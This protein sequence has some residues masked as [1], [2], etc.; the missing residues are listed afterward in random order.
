MFFFFFIF[1]LKNLFYNFPNKKYLKGIFHIHSIHFTIM[2]FTFCW[3]V[4]INVSTF[5]L[6]PI[7]CKIMMEDRYKGNNCNIHIFSFLLSF[8]LIQIVIFPIFTNFYFFFKLYV[9]WSSI[10]YSLSI[11]WDY[12]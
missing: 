4:Y 2:L 5:H 9:I 8:V 10:C 6:A 1:N 11:Q 7:F 3:F 12:V